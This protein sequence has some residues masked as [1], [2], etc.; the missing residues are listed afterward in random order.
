MRT[1][2]LG[3]TIRY[4]SNRALIGVIISIRGDRI[5]MQ[6]QNVTIDSVWEQFEHVKGKEQ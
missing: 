1:F 6:C 2:K 4:I 3:D 5:I